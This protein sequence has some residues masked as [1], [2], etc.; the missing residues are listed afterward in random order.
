MLDDLYLE[1]DATSHERILRDG[2]PDW[3][4]DVVAGPRGALLF[5]LDLSYRPDLDERVLKFGP[6]RDATFRFR[7]PAYVGTPADVLRIDADGV[8]KVEHAAGPGF[9]EIRDRTSRVAIYLATSIPGERER[10]D[11]RRR[12]LAADEAALGFDPGRN[13]ADLAV[14]RDWTRPKD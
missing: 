6:P 11:A 5:A 3:D 12:S 14:L 9:V 7:L 10:L 1:G 13:P 8:A 4:L 2:K